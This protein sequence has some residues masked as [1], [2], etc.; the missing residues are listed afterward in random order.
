MKATVVAQQEPPWI[1]SA[2]VC[3]AV[4]FDDENDKVLG[5][6]KVDMV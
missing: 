4:G 3:Q 6:A 1:R 5:Y 2:P